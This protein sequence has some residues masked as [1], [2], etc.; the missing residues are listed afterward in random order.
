MTEQERQSIEVILARM[1][2]D[3]SQ[4]KIDLSDL[5][6]AVKQQTSALYKPDTGIFSRVQS[7][8]SLASGA[9]K[10]GWLIVGSL[11]ALFTP[12]IIILL[13]TAL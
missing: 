3:I 5:K 7:V 1:E 10:L 9:K 2:A 11:V 6:T 4:I 12:A 13:L 8:E